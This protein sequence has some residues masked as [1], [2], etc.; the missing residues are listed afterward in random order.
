MSYNF[1]T[2]ATIE[3]NFCLLLQKRSTF[4]LMFIWT[5]FLFFIQE[6]GHDVLKHI[7]DSFCIYSGTWN[8]ALYEALARYNK[9]IPIFVKFR[10]VAIAQNKLDEHL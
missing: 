4:R 8:S 10:T 5:L 2:E 9:V 1:K 7:Y 6:H 3:T